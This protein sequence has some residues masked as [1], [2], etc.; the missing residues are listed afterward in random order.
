M[1]TDGEGTEN[2][3]GGVSTDG[4]MPAVSDDSQA[5]LLTLYETGMI[6]ARQRA[7]RLERQLAEMQR[8][9]APTPEAPMDNNAF[10]QDSARN[11]ENIVNKALDARIKPLTDFVAETRGATKYDQIKDGLR[12]NPGFKDK[13]DSIEPYLDEIMKT[14]EVSEQNV[15]TAALSIIGAMATGQLKPA[16]VRN[17]RPAGAPPP[18]PQNP[19][20]TK[21]DA[22]MMPAHLRPSGP[23]VNNAPVKK[24]R[25]DLTELE[26]R[27]RREQRMTKDEYLDEL[28]DQRPMVIESIMPKKKPD[29]NEAAKK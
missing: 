4:G 8:A 3:D 25:R 29:P 27:I 12:K 18:T 2:A 7:D 28:E 1:L 20:T 23:S 9:P 15:N 13:M 11:I 5:R 16:E 14:T 21:N 17:N 6:E 24:E 26:E 19:S 10:W 22:T